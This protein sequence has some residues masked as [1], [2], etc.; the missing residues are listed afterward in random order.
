MLSSPLLDSSIPFDM[1]CSDVSP[2]ENA[3][4]NDR[5]A[6]SVFSC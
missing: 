3:S 4:D 1:K 2:E 6:K 5:K